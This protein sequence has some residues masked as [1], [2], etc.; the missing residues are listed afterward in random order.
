M[1]KSRKLLSIFLAVLMV[2]TSMSVLAFAKTDSWKNKGTDIYNANDKGM[3]YLLTD[4]ERAAYVCDLV[5]NLLKSAAIYQDVTVAKI[6]LRSLDAAL[7][8]LNSYGGLIK[9]ADTFYDLGSLAGLNYSVFTDTKYT[10]DGSGDV[11]ILNALLAFLD[12][13]A[14]TLGTELKN[15]FSLGKVESSAGLDLSAI[16]DIP[17]LVKKSLNDIG[18]RRLTNGIGADLSYPDEP[19]WDDLSDAQK[20]AKT[21]DSIVQDLL[22]GLITEPSSTTYATKSGDNDIIL[23]STA[24]GA[25]PAM[26]HQEADT[27]YYYIY[28]M[29]NTTG[30]WSFS[31]T[32]DETT[33]QY[34]THWDESSILMPGFD[35]SMIDFKSTSIYDLVGKI[36]PVIYN[37]Y[38]QDGLNGKLRATL[39]Q[40][41]G[42]YNEGVTDATEKAAVKAEFDRY[43]AMSDTDFAA[44]LAQDGV[45]GCKNFLY[46]TLD[47]NL[48]YCV[49]WKGSYE[50]YKVDLTNKTAFYDQMNWEYQIG[51]WDTVWQAA[52]GVAYNYQTADLVASVNNIM[53]YIVASA[54]KYT[55]WT[56]DIEPLNG[57]ANTNIAQN[58]SNL[59]KYVISI[60]PEQIFGSGT[61][62]PEGFADYNLEQVA[63]TIAK[64]VIGDLMPSLILPDS[65]SSLEELI[66]YGVREFIAEI[67][68]EL[69]WDTEI[70]AAASKTGAEKEDAFLDIALRMGSSIA[71]Y[72]LREVMGYTGTVSTSTSWEAN[73]D[74]ILE[75]ILD[76]WVPGLTK[77][78]Q[79]QNATVFKGSDPLAKLSIIFNTLFPSALKLIQGCDAT[80]GDGTNKDC[81]VSVQTLYDLVRGLLNGEISP[82]AEK[83]HRNPNPI[84][85]GAVYSGLITIVE[86]LLGGLGLNQSKDYLSLKGVFTTALA[87]TTPLDSLMGNLNNLIANL[88]WSITDTNSFVDGTSYKMPD[89]WMQDALRVV[90]QVMGAMD[91]MSYKGTTLATDKTEYIGSATASVTPTVTFSVS[92]IEAAFNNGAYGTGTLTLDNSYTA[93][94]QKVEITDLDG[95]VKATTGD[96]NQALTANQGYSTNALSFAA[97]SAAQPYTVTAYFQVFASDGTSIS[98][99]DQLTIR[100]MIVVSSQAPG[101][102]KTSFTILNDG[103][104]AY[105]NVQNQYID[106]NTPFGQAAVAQY[107]FIEGGTGKRACY[108][109]GYGTLAKDATTGAVTLSGLGTQQGQAGGKNNQGN[110][111]MY[112]KKTTDGVEERIKITEQTSDKVPFYWYSKQSQNENIMWF[113]DGESYSNQLWMVDDTISRNSVTADF[114]VYSMHVDAGTKT[115]AG[116][117]GFIIHYKLN[118]WGWG[119]QT[120]GFSFAKDPEIVAFNSYGLERKINQAL[121]SGRNQAD[122]TADSWA[123]YVA[124]LNAAVAEWNVPRFADTFYSNHTDSNDEGLSD[125]LVCAN[126][127][128][129]AVEGLTSINEGSGNS[130][131]TQEQTAALANLKTQLDGQVEKD[132]SN[133]DFIAYRWWLYYN[134]Y[135]E[136]DNFYNATQAPAAP[137]ATL[138]GVADKDV[139]AAIAALPTELQALAAALK[140]GVTEDQTKAYNEAV[141]YYNENHPSLDISDL[142]VQ[143]GKLTTYDS[144]LLADTANKSYLNSA[145]TQVESLAQGADAYTAQ[146]Y[147][148][149]TT[150]L[151][152][153]KAVQAD[154]A[155]KPSAIHEARYDVLVAYN[156]LVGADVA[157]DFT[158][159]NA[160][161]AQANTIL[162]NQDIYKASDA[163]KAANPV[164]DE[165]TAKIN[166]L[167]SVLAAVGEKVTVGTTDYVIGGS[168]AAIN[169]QA[170]EGMYFAVD[171]AR[172]DW[173][174]SQLAKAMSNVVCNYIAESN[175]TDVKITVDNGD[176]LITG[177]TPGSLNTSADIAGK[178]VANNTTDTTLTFNAN[179]IGG[180]GTGANGILALKT[181]GSTIATY[182]IVVYGDVNGDGVIDAFDSAA[183][184]LAVNGKTQ[185]KGAY[186]TAGGL[187]SGEIN[188]ENY[189][190]IKNAVVGIGEI[191]Q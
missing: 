47:S 113:I 110:D 132:Y 83:L 96:I 71:V 190:T 76:K 188:A 5:D 153:A 150:A 97:P 182:V 147:T 95:V 157:A 162:E 161:I 174:V 84:G 106:E 135:A 114:T 175:G 28:G 77:V 125:F 29:K 66:V 48:Y 14:A 45:Y 69:N 51:D 12:A 33:K 173:A 2:L 70:A 57:G 67:L 137:V 100:K 39:M 123:A 30:T 11:A 160:L 163:Y 24:Y 186:R 60:N 191:A 7:A 90:L 35:T 131:Y 185:L 13:N 184:D 145:V 108:V 81:A 134:K 8:T 94:L 78:M 151:A 49:E 3:S 102:D 44:A 21:L 36:G 59:I 58:A 146:S 127:L 120:Y 17:G 152:A 142:K 41:C 54:T 183:M 42:A 6:D 40:W 26:I 189:G 148:A 121:N 112:W 124:A 86:E 16:K 10:R 181:D 138:A 89:L 159:L 52:T 104:N 62:L 4:E 177:V 34:I 68:P 156:K 166:A 141:D 9:T 167:A 18:V 74:G 61:T 136:L 38:G 155:A 25:T 79:D 73:I 20:S 88:I 53:G 133:K 165:A 143:Q 65:V 129:A 122:Y 80:V 187:E 91:E 23:N 172:I 128:D 63:V 99:T 164:M 101:D 144:R 1:K 168:D 171:Q 19:K 75:F 46:F 126:D 43:I 37:A 107:T 93:T 92:G 149:Y 178:V 139:D 180:F 15:G 27:G 64:L 116:G 176:Y 87:T 72:Y 154:S 82:I 32:G 31:E 50:L 103:S 111:V 170:D 98:G 105:Y 117:H 158:Q 115:G 119:E 118:D 169:Y 55:G 109:W 179:D 140:V 22:I 56:Q 85:D 130:S